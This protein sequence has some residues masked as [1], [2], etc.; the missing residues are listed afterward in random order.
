[1][2]KLALPAALTTAVA[3]LLTKKLFYGA[4][5][6]CAAGLGLGAWLEPPRMPVASAATVVTPPQEPANVW[7]EAP[8]DISAVLYSQPDGGPVESQTA[9][10]SRPAPEDD[11]SPEI[12][13]V[14]LA[15]ADP[16]QVAAAGDTSHA[17]AK[18]DTA[19]PADFANPPDRTRPQG[20]DWASY[21]SRPR[22]NDRSE[23]RRVGKE[24]S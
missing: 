3:P 11:A 14:A 17:E 19:P 5:I 10:V 24:C 8:S 9:A 7:G 15:Q 18:A 12:Q 1:M 4:A 20:R 16:R 23:E 6:A 2:F 13:P 22:D 21:D